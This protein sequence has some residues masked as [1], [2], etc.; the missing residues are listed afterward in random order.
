[1][2]LSIGM[3]HLVSLRPFE[4]YHS[5]LQMAYF[6]D[7]FSPE[8]YEA[9]GRSDR[10]VSGFRHRQRNI[11]ERVKR[12][13]RFVCYMTR[14]SRW[15]GLLE[16]IE[17]PFH[18]SS[19]IFHQTDDPFV[20]RFRVKPVVW[21]PVEKSIPIHDDALWNRLS[22]TKGHSKATS[23]WT[24]K[25]R[26]SLA[27]LNDDDGV[28]IEALLRAQASGGR[29]YPLDASDSRRLA[30]HT[31]RHADKDVVVTVPEDGDEGRAAPPAD[32]RESIQVQALLAEIGSRMGMKIW[33]PRSDRSAVLAEW[34]GDH[35]DLL[36]RLPLNYDDTTLKTIEQID[37]LWLKG[38]SIRRAFEVDGLD[39][40][41]LADNAPTWTC[42]TLKRRCRQARCRERL[43]RGHTA[44]VISSPR[45]ASSGTTSFHNWKAN[46]FCPSRRG[47]GT[48]I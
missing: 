44:P 39:H 22:F 19:P 45:P 40:M 46:R 4:Q 35:G 26:A 29:D 36:D 12:G 13:D 14:V 6:L 43:K 7:L 24:G 25:L 42:P 2:V 16:V 34:K 15:F 20:V 21:L 18:D 8:T 23:S 3:G 32:V 30:T 1:M 27:P 10:T 17:G 37:V 47:P 5:Y 33:V 11:A 31:V 28:H 38:R 9:F 48:S 41:F